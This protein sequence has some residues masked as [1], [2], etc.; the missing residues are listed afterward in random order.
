[1]RGKENF[2]LFFENNAERL[3]SSAEEM[4]KSIK[5]TGHKH[6]SFFENENS[7]ELE[8]FKIADKSDF[9]IFLGA[10]AISKKAR[11]LEKK[12]L[13]LLENNSANNLNKKN[14]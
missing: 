6:V 12:M 1:M 14:I 9:I 4:I 2:L 5:D 10:G 7:M 3:R 8:L 11:A 13:Q